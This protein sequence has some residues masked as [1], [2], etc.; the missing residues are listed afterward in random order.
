MEEDEAR[1]LET[2][3]FTFMTVLVDTSVIIDFLR[4]KKKDRTWW[5]QLATSNALAIALITHTE[6]YAGSSVWTN[7]RARQELD[8]L[9]SAVEM[10]PMSTEISFRAAQ[11]RARYSVHLIDSIIAATSLVKE[12]PLATLNRAHFKKITGL[13]L[14]DLPGNLA[15]KR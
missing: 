11:N 8:L 13:K 3:I 15:A 7:Q 12:L 4:R 5:Y 6:L 9:F 2:H 14:L 1:R 10:V